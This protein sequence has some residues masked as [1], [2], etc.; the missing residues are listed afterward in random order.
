MV[1]GVILVVNAGKSSR[2]VVKRSRQIL[3]DIGAR[4]FG[5]VLNNDNRRNQDNYYYYQS[6][7]HREG[8][9]PTEEQE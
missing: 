1:D 8:Y 4:I 2:Q 6:Y 9:R 3:T 7:Y 5:V